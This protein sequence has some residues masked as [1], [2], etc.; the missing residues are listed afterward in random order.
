VLAFPIYNIDFE[1]YCYSLTPLFGQQGFCAVPFGTLSIPRFV[2]ELHTA[3]TL[4]ADVRTFAYRLV[5]IGTR[6]ST[7]HQILR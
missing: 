6:F 3:S 1:F 4:S 5:R 7:A 2:A